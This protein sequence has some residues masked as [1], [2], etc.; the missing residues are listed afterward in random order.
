MISRMKAIAFDRIG[1]P[2]EVL[3]LVEIPEP[4]IG[5]RQV[6][7][8][9][10]AASI[11]PGD[12]LFTQSLYPEPKKP[13]FPQQIAGGHAAGVVVRAARGVKLEPGTLV[14][15]SYENAWA[16]YAAVPA[17]W[18]IPLPADL[19]LEKAGQF[20]NFITA[21]DLLEGVRVQPGQWLALTA[22]HA[23]VSTMVSQLAALRGVNVLSIVR[24]T[25]PGLD[26]KDFGA[27]AVLD[28]S[29]ASDDIGEGVRDITGGRGISALIDNVG[30]PATGE[31]IRAMAFGGRALVCGGFGSERFSLHNFDLLLNDVQL[32]AYVYRYFFDPPRKADF[33]MLGRLAETVA[34][35][36]FRVRV[37]GEHRLDD[38]AAAVRESWERP[39][40][41]KRFFIMEEKSR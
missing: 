22:G 13:L 25:R 10:L 9:V 15:F 5:P 17:E 21:W 19:P 38:F 4:E 1:L 37:G 33:D 7:V 27:S 3:R 12:F 11:N 16:E 14:A 20:M 39:E 29:K 23:T 18:L 36:S 41:G 6:L 31:L 34:P 28:L 2:T 8:K 26:L 40:A 35:P 32:G 24:R 30:G